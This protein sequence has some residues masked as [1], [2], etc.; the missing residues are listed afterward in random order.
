MTLTFWQ[1]LMILSAGA[2]LMALGAI[3]AGVLV[4]KTKYAGQSMFHGEHVPQGDAFNIEDDFTDD[5]LNLG[6]PEP[7][8]LPEEIQAANEKFLEQF[9]MKR[10]IKESEKY[11]EQ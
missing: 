3:I 6:A 1:I 5:P 11:A 4:Y 7:K 2:I 9:N 8:E 10:L